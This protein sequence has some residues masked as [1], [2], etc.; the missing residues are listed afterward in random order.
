MMRKLTIGLFALVAL[1]IGPGVASAANIDV[2]Y[3][4]TGGFAPTGAGT[5]TLTMAAPVIGTATIRYTSPASAPTSINAGAAQLQT[6]SIFQQ[7]TLT[8]AFSVQGAIFNGYVGIQMNTGGQAGALTGGGALGFAGLNG[9]QPLPIHCNAAACPIFGLTGFT[10]MQFSAG[11]AIVGLSLNGAG[12]LGTV[13]PG[14]VGLSSPQ[15]TSFLGAGITFNVTGTEV[16][17]VVAPIPEPGT[18]M[19]LMLGLTG[20]AGVSSAARRRS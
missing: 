15:L 9:V 19:L 20:L 16:S 13:A 6:F 5:G 8:N 17:R 12:H 1:A 7:W 11:T 4:L 18:G 14:I 2:T 3:N 10:S